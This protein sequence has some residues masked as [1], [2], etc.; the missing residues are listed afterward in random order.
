MWGLSFKPRTDDIREAPAIDIIQGLLQRGANVH[1]TDPAAIKPM[2]MVLPESNTLKYFR[3]N[4]D[5][6]EGA[7]ALVI[8]TEW[9]EFRNPNFELIEQ[10]LHDKVI[11][12]G[13][14]IYD[15]DRMRENGF[16]YYGIGR[17]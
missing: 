8:V 12:D 2:K 6:L 16:M 10:K 11:F 4:T 7:D 9:N 14:N 3:K 5:A 15:P 1:A 13:R 17:R